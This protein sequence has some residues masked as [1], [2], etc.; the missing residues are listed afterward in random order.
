MTDLPHHRPNVGVVLFHPDGRVWYGRRAGT[1]E[2]HCWQF[3]QG[4]VD[5]GEDYEAAA[6]RELAEETGVVSVEPLAEIQ[7]WIAYDFPPDYGGTKQARGWKGQK[8]K[9][10]AFR[11]TGEESEIDLEQ[12]AEIE[13]DAWRW[14]RLDEAPGLIVPFKRA[15]YE[16]V[17]SAFAPLVV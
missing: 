12:H 11:F 2:P 17:V 14:G 1:P 5:E 4:G 15:A 6:R 9:W 16:Q 10:F 8:Q 13:F 3:P 7:Q